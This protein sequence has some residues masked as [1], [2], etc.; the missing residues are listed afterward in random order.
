MSEE[1]VNAARK[2]YAIELAV[3]TVDSMTQDLRDADA[4]GGEVGK[5]LI[6]LTGAL[7]SAKD[8][9]YRDAKGMARCR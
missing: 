1:Y 4:D 7:H 2:L 5:A 3:K 6:R 8:V 9:A